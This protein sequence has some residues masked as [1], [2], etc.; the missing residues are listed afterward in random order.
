MLL[1]KEQ[2]ASLTFLLIFIIVI[3]TAISFNLFDFKVF[4]LTYL[5][6]GVSY[7]SF[8]CFRLITND[9]IKER[10][11]AFLI[12]ILFWI[13]TVLWIF[14][15]SI[16]DYVDFYRDEV[17][18]R[19]SKKSVTYSEHELIKALSVI[20]NSDQLDLEFKTQILNS[21]K[22]KN[23]RLYLKLLRT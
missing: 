10:I 20:L 23:K 4:L 2:V 5:I 3:C 22:K 7:A 11:V 15:K 8:F 17:L 19:I 21:L 14:F 18:N 12:L 1:D 6:F 13:T 16:R 9:E